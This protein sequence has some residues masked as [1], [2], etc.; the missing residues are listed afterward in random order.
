MLTQDISRCY[1]DLAAAVVSHAVREANLTNWHKRRDE[2][3]RWLAETGADW[4]ELLTEDF[5]RDQWLEWIAA[6]CK[7]NGRAMTGRIK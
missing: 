5:S 4:M 1:A 2:A 7:Y 3:R 6:G